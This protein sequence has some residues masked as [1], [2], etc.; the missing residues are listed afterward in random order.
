MLYGTAGNHNL[1]DTSLV[2]RLQYGVYSFLHSPAMLETPTESIFAPSTKRDRVA[3]AIQGW[4]SWVIRPRQQ[5]FHR[6]FVRPA[7]LLL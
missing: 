2:L 6:S 5:R 4:A 1:N 7:C 3:L